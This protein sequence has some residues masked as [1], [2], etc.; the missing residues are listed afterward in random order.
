MSMLPLS[1]RDPSA[2]A[3]EAGTEAAYF[4]AEIPSS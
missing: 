1:S 3:D 4:W 2:N